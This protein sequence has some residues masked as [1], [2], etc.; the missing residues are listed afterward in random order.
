MTQKIGIVLLHGAGTPN[1]DFAK[2]MIKE[3]T[4]GF[5]SKLKVED[6][7]NNLVF[8]SVFWSSIF[9]NEENTLWERV[10]QGTELD[11]R[12]LRSF[13]V[14]FLADAVAYQPSSVSD[15]NYD[16]VHALIAQCLH[17]LQ[18]KAGSCAPLCVI[19]HSLGSV[20]ASN[21]FYDLQARQENIGKI[22][23][24]CSGNTPL[25]KGET[26]SLFYS[27]GSPIALWSLR[28]NDFGMPIRVPPPEI[29]KYYP[30]INGE[31]LNF[32]DKDDIL[33]YPLKGLNQ[34]YQHAVTKD[35][36]VNVGGL[37]TNWN[38]FS[39]IKYDIDHSVI[40]P[41]VDGLVRTWLK[42]NQ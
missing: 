37:L 34:H 2:E 20:V 6:P 31:W 40:D 1:K 27:M 3:I 38:L 17:S 15:Q 5:S 21:Y 18:A 24:Q 33:A 19:S 8:Q 41:I 16:K 13:V 30:N 29:Q 36:E 23:K 32:Y 14:E 39:H 28:F 10:Q 4:K 9:E 35:V 12:F 26:L 22:T 7:E 25:E 11:Y 42:V